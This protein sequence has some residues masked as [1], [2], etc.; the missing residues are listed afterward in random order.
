MILIL[1]L[2][3]FSALILGFFGRII[4]Y[5]GAM[6]FSTFL[7]SLTLIFCVKTFYTI[8]ICSNSFIINLST[9]IH[10]GIF[11][12]Q[13]SLLFDSL[14]VSMLLIIGSISCIVHIY[15]TIYLNGDPHIIRFLCYLSFF[16]FYML[17]LITSNNFLQ[18]FLAW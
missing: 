11:M 16:T 1:L 17:L 10:S 3:L 15:S 13:W 18:L 8:G 4:G 9:W 14:T 5:K 7:L 6:F 12:L 2:P